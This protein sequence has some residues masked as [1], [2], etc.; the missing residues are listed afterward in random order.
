MLLFCLDGIIISHDNS[1]E[2]ITNGN[3]QINLSELRIR[4]ATFIKYG[5]GLQGRL[6]RLDEVFNLIINSDSAINALHLKGKYQSPEYLEALLL[7]IKNF[8]DIKDKIFI[9]DLKPD[10]AEF[11]KIN[12]S[13]LKT[14]ASLA[15][16]YD[17]ER[18]NQFVGGTLISIDDALKY[19]RIKLYDWAWMDEWDK[20]STKGYK[21]FYTEA[22]FG[23]LRKVGYNLALVSPELH[24]KSPGLYGGE[25]HQ[26]AVTN[27]RLFR[28]VR[29]ILSLE[30]D[31]IC[32]D[33]PKEVESFLCERK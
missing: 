13:D 7:A 17:I 9:F 16:P 30:P 2:R 3:V 1:F 22:N 18:F 25:E 32:T 19:K 21:S 4:E 26:D 14:G 31:A 23:V 8:P 12:M 33:Y 24:K 11:I 5:G 28:R 29:E 6:A 15:H 10:A 27:D 20:K